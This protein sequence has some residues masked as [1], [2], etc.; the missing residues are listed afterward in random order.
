MENFI[1][2]KT[3]KKFFI[4]SHKMIFKNGKLVN[5]DKK[6]VILTNPENGNALVAIPKTGAPQFL[7]SNDKVARKEM[8][9]KRS[10]DH[11]QKEIKEKRYEMNKELIKN[12][13]SK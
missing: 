12:F 2:E 6:G 7:K 9:E 5:A 10:K 1:D 4:P 3:G 13:E 8:L 11:Y